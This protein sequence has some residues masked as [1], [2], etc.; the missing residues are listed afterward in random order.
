MF[1][2]ELPPPYPETQPT[3]SEPEESKDSDLHVDDC[4]PQAALAS[5]SLLWTAVQRL[6]PLIRPQVP[7]GYKRIT[8]TCVSHSYMR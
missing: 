2:S 1:P 5:R 8:W 3:A 7:E 6:R 4:R